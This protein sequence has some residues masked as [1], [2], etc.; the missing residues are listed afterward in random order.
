MQTPLL[1]YYPACSTC[2]K[3]IKYLRDKEVSVT[4]R[5][6]VEECPTSDELTEW[7]SKSGLPVSKFFNTSGRVYREQNIKEAIKS[8]SEEEQISWLSHN[9]MLIKRPL[10]IDPKGSVLVGFR[11]DEWEHWV[12]Q[13]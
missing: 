4:L 12:Q 7:I 1:L 11:Q 2:K 8:A 9:G 13:R 10:L 6:I 5:H 3:A